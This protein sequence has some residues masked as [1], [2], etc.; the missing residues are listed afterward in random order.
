M[1]AKQGAAF[2]I[3]IHAAYF[4]VFDGLQTAKMIAAVSREARI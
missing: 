2:V 3:F 1:R 4:I